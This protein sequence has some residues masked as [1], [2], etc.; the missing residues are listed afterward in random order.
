MGGAASR[1]PS[2]SRTPSRPAVS[3]PSA[4][5]IN[6]PSVGGG[7]APSISRPSVG[8]GGA[9]SI[10]RP[11]IGGGSPSISRPSVGGGAPSISR[12]SVGG[13]LASRPGLGGTRP[14]LGNIRPD[15]LQRP[16]AGSFERPS[17][18]QLQDFL[19]LPGRP[20]A[21]TRPAVPD[22]PGISTLPGVIDRPGI[23][24]LPGAID[25][26]GI[27]TLP[28]VIDRPGIGDRPGISTLPG[29]ID[30]PGIGDRPGISTLPG[31]IDRPGVGDRLPDR[32]PDRID[33]IRD[34][35]TRPVAN[36]P[37]DRN[38][39]QNH[40]SVVVNWN[41][42]WHWHA[43]WNRY[44][45]HW[46]WRPATWTAFG[47]WFAWTWARPFNYEFGSTVIVRNNYIFVNDQQVATVEAFHEQAT[48][49]AENV[50]EEFDGEKAEWM[51]L[52]VFAIAEE[53]ATTD[54]G[55]MIQ[56]AV[57]RQGVISGTF[58]NQITDTLRPLVGSVDQ[59]S[60][61][62]AWMFADDDD[63]GIIMETGIYN[64]TRDDATALV[65]F[66]SGKVQTWLLVRLPEPE[67]DAAAQPE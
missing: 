64:L 33:R 60:Q 38:W 15:G 7:G 11:S 34:P 18:G 51:P 47:G 4:P 12:P 32:R 28:S 52:G 54:T 53:T 62:A 22:R 56:L 43:G 8:G 48:T 17:A 19:D 31:A 6:R 65:H 5:S 46:W 20:G 58:Y 23:S 21:S 59:T 26:P 55:M 45:A 14:D 49:I 2:L 37:F 25:R 29:A 9:P 16:G 10:S 13:D 66:G 27:S 40:Q 57:S 61:R 50:P 35:W 67:E 24:T 36:R 42:H 41:T 44:P 39:W 1:T 30:R 3:R 63:S